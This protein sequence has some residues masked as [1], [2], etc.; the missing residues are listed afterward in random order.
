MKK[1]DIVVGYYLFANFNGTWMWSSTDNV[2]R[3]PSC[4]CK[5]DTLV[6]NPDYA[7]K[8]NFKPGVLGVGPAV[9]MS[10]SLTSTYDCYDIATSGFKNYC[11]AQSY[12]NLE[13][14]PLKNDPNHFHLKCH[15]V[16][17]ID[18]QATRLRFEDLCPICNNYRNLIFSNPDTLYINT[19]QPIPDGIFRSD[20]FLASGDNRH[21]L[22]IIGPETMLKFKAI[23]IK[24]LL[25]RNVY[26]SRE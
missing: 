13:F 12:K 15:E 11:E 23:G 1:K 7:F 24:K 10:T 14:V 8:R 21:Q 16:I 5:L 25:Y 4:K 6:T 2:L 9:P 19:E 17:A 22:L 20:V 18:T 26:T 3:C